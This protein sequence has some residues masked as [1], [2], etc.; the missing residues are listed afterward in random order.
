MHWKHVDRSAQVWQKLPEKLIKSI[1]IWLD[2]CPFKSTTLIE[3]PRQSWV[4]SFT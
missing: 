1:T 2:N 3:N 4:L